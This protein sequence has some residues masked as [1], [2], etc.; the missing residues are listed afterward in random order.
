MGFHRG[1]FATRQTSVW[2][3]ASGDYTLSTVLGA[4]AVE[5]ELGRIY[6][7]W[8]ETETGLPNEMT[9]ADRENFEDELRKYFK[10]VDRLDMVSEYL[11]KLKFNEF[12]R[13]DASLNAFVVKAHPDA[14]SGPS[15][16]NF[17]ETEL[18]WKRNAIAHAGKI[19]SPAT[20]ITDTLHRVRLARALAAG[21][22]APLWIGN[23]PLG[24]SP[25][26]AVGTPTSS[27]P[28]AA[29]GNLFTRFAPCCQPPGSSDQ[30]M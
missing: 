2:R 6:I 3:L 26:E 1:G 9:D 14:A 30:V 23:L 12:V 25:L 27:M 7:K 8:R 29:L 19:D 13:A 4:V 28:A 15:L 16:K 21:R 18:F 20:W 17:F 22:R 5:S 24:F 10:I 11:T